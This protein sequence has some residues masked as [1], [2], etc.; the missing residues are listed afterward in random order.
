MTARQITR[1]VSKKA[2]ERQARQLQSTIRREANIQRHTSITAKALVYAGHLAA[3]FAL[4][5]VRLGA[6]LVVGLVTFY[7]ATV[8]VAVLRARRWHAMRP[9]SARTP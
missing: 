5:Q 1:A 3:G 4:A 7:G 6:W 9:E 8:V 2:R